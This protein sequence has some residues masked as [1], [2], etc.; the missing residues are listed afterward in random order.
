MYIPNTN[1]SVSSTTT[2]AVAS[3]PPKG[4]LTPP[5][6]SS[7]EIT[8]I[9]VT[10]TNDDTSSITDEDLNYSKDEELAAYDAQRELEHGEK[11]ILLR[12]RMRQV[13]FFSLKFFQIDS[14]PFFFEV[15]N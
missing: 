10:P 13:K 5:L 14:P 8:S 15:I 6:I 4:N 1:K 2:R 3:F 12:K 11:I 9:R 7:S